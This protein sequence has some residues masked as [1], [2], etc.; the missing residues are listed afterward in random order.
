MRD[1]SKRFTYT[2]EEAGEML[3]I[4]RNH[5]YEAAK[6]GEIPT[7]TLGTRKV[8]PKA[9]FDRMLGLI[10]PPGPMPGAVVETAEPAPPTARSTTPARK[11]G[12]PAKAA[13]VAP[14]K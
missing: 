6:R 12:R 10:E 5:A 2:V 1:L 9:T 3:G 8:V 14:S 7:I 11:R 4:G 13:A